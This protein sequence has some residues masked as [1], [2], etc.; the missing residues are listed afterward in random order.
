MSKPGVTRDK[1]IQVAFDL[2]WDNSY[3]AVSV[4][5]ICERAGVLKGS[6]Y[7]FFDSKADLVVA[8]YEQHWKEKRPHMDRI[9]SPQVAPLERIHL[10]CEFI[11]AV[12]YEKAEKY[13]HVCG[14]P[15]ASVGAEVATNDEKIRRKSE[16][17]MASAIKYVENAIADAMRAE[18]VTVKDAK[19]AARC[20]CSVATG[21]MVQAK[22]ENDLEIL[23]DLE[24]AIMKLLGAKEVVS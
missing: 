21:M 24:P 10:W 8:A 1:L 3:G 6:F 19:H 9:F 2:I 11:C 20:I 16:E 14:C 4:G 17:L 13:G 18:V 5:D 7:H 15:F 22:V 23:K 12:Q